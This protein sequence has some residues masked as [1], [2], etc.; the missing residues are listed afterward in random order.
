MAFRLKAFVRSSAGTRL[1]INDCR[2]GRS[3]VAIAPVRE[4]M[5]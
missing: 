4:T 1:G 3:K 2:A 5:P